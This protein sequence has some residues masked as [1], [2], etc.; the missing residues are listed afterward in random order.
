V[1]AALAGSALGGRGLAG[2]GLGVSAAFA[3]EPKAGRQVPGIYRINVGDIEVTAI[4]DGYIELGAN[5]FPD[6]KLDEVNKLQAANFAPV[7]D[8]VRASVNA[9]VINTGDKL[10]IIDAGGRNLLGPTMGEL[11]ANLSAAGINPADVDLVIATHM[12][13]DHI[14]GI[15]T[16]NGAAAFEN[17]QL[18]VHADEW[19]YWLSAENMSKAGES[20]APFFQAAQASVTPYAKMVRKIVGDEE[21]IPGVRSVALP[22]HTPGHTGYMVTSGPDALLIW[23]DIVH[24][25]ILQFPHPNWSI[26]FDVSP[27]K[28]IATRKKAFDLAM[29]DRLLVAGMHLPYPG[30]GYVTKGGG[31]YRFV[32]AEWRFSL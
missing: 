25:V 5:L 19:D 4:L 21:V 31:G 24:S 23:G 14:G 2:A 3:A 17:A 20:A 13:P 27:E 12:H 22:G 16:K 28:G 32:P 15:T 9:F 18:V 8:S 1:G 30:L 26:A 10:A 11:P 7:G 29:T 6:A